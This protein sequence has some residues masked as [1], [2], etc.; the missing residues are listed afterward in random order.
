MINFTIYTLEEKCIWVSKILKINKK[1]TIG[2]KLMVLFVF[3]N[4][5]LLYDN[6]LLLISFSLVVDKRYIIKKVLWITAIITLN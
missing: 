5:K 3:T 6:L 4:Q 1:S 2:Y